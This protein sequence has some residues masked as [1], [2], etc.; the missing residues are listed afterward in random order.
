[1]ADWFYL[2]KIYGDGTLDD[3]REPSPTVGPYRPA[4]EDIKAPGTERAALPWK[5]IIGN[6]M[7]TGAPLHAWAIVVAR[8]DDHSVVQGNS[9]IV[10]LSVDGNERM[11][12]V[13]ERSRIR[14]ILRDAGIPTRD[15]R[16]VVRVRAVCDQFIKMH[17]PE[18][19]FDRLR[20]RK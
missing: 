5:I 9:D 11:R 3:G 12:D 4:I 17:Q 8:G 10:F 18:S 19:S 2:C 14:Q 13:S 1:M 16:D 20:F 6:N 15:M 7:Q